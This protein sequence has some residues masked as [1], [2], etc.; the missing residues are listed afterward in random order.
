MQTE[1]RAGVEKRP[2]QPAAN[3]HG[4]EFARHVIQGIDTWEAEAQG[5]D[6]GQI[7]P[8]ICACPARLGIQEGFDEIEHT[9]QAEE[10]NEVEA[11]HMWGLDWKAGGAL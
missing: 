8:G 2:Q 7:V 3:F 6:C 1:D 4:S 11:R 10:S 9:A 5:R